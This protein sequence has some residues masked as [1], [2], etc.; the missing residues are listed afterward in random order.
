MDKLEELDKIV[1]LDK[2]MSPM[3][4]GLYNL[5]L[6]TWIDLPSLPTQRSD[7]KLK[8]FST[9]SPLNFN[10]PPIL[11]GYRQRCDSFR[12]LLL[13]FRRKQSFPQASWDC[14]VSRDRFLQ[15]LLKLNWSL[16]MRLERAMETRVGAGDRAQ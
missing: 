11:S 6:D 10:F 3:P 8:V 1:K 2:G 4:R 15:M 14:L 13:C 12:W 9:S 5:Q 7:F 16:L